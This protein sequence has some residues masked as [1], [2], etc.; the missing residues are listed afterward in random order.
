[1]ASDIAIIKRLTQ[2]ALDGGVSTRFQARFVASSWF[3]QSSV[4]S[5]RSPVSRREHA[6]H[7]ASRWAAWR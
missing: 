5:S 7:N 6:G 1:M 3:R 2:R 4:V